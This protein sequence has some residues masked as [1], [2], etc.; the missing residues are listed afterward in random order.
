MRITILAVVTALAMT[1]S[2]SAETH[3][4]LVNESSF[5]PETLVVAPGDTIVFALT[6]GSSYTVVR[7]GSD[8]IPDNAFFAGGL[9]NGGMEGP[10]N[11]SFAWEVPAYASLEIPYFSENSC[12]QGMTGLII[13][14]AGGN[15][16]QV[17]DDYPVL[18]D[19]IEAAQDGDTIELAAGTYYEHDLQLAGKQLTL[20]GETTAGGDPAVTIDAAQQGRVV[21]VYTRL[22][23]PPAV[24]GQA[25]LE[26][27][28][29][30]GGI[31]AGGL[32]VEHASPVVRNCRFIGN[33]RGIHVVSGAPGTP[34]LAANPQLIDCIFEGNGDGAV[35]CGLGFQNGQCQPTLSGCLVTGNMGSFG[36][37]RA[38]E[39]TSVMVYNSIICGNDGVQLLGD[40]QL[41]GDSCSAPI[42]ID[43]DGDGVPEGCLGD[44][45]GILNVP[46]EYP[47]I[48]GAIE[49][50]NDGQTVMIA[51]GTYAF[52]GDGGGPGADPVFFVADKSITIAGE[53]NADGSPAVTIEGNEGDP[54]AGIYVFG[55][56]EAVTL[57]HLKIRGCYIGIT[58]VGGSHALTNCIL[59]NNYFSGLAVQSAQVVASDSVIRDGS[60][61]LLVTGSSEQTDVSLV[62]C[63]IENNTGGIYS[64]GIEVADGHL[65][66][67][68][69]IVRGNAVP[70]WAATG[71]MSI[72]SSAS[73]TLSDTIV[74]ANFV[75]DMPGVQ[76]EGDWTDAGGSTVSEECGST[77]HVPADY[78]TIQ[79]AIDA[80][81]TFDTIELAAGTYAL[82]GD[83]SVLEITNK[84][85]TLIG[86]T[87]PDGTI[88][89]TIQGDPSNSTTSV[90]V[91]GDS[92]HAVTLSHLR[93]SGLNLG[94]QGPATTVTDCIIEGGTSGV[95][96]FEADVT[97]VRC[98][99]R[100]H[101]AIGFCGV[102]VWSVN[103]V[104]TL[105]LV[106]CI[107]ED[108]SANYET[109]G[110]WPP[111]CG[112]IVYG[113]QL[114]VRGCTIRNNLAWGTGGA[115]P[116]AGIGR[117]I[118]KGTGAQDGPFSLQDTSLCG[119]LE[120]GEP[121]DQIFGEVIDGGGNTIEDECTGDCPGDFD[122]SGTVDVSDLLAVIGSWGDP[123]DV[124]DLLLVISEWGESC[125]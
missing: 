27:I 16:L 40:I 55:S 93:M 102:Y 49:F 47:D 9:P 69:C 103:D 73:A 61:G 107:V 58:L 32:L 3:E 116:F 30:T 39:G 120:D 11:F 122:G 82:D 44:Q 52:S 124:G 91:L 41:D 85:L 86:E 111:H 121:Q 70:A 118:F 17:P 59:E 20:R 29:I 117:R 54:P 63:R 78:A 125:P 50:A 76:I 25:V 2:V 71:G 123:Y 24:T 51:A 13:I 65:S 57:E 88:A 98:T 67:E 119:N 56:E 53:R 87:N 12:E 46:D 105:E 99:I 42:C 35:E 28:V 8:C 5:S 84:T 34:T 110:W 95:G 90:M 14:D 6:A 19:A 101:H 48:Q 38:D 68:Q 43:D 31:D 89:A 60:T 81:D 96:I 7:S 33:S 26:N 80:A 15:T 115:S 22:V 18:A 109:F 37:V 106:D 94:I 100:D 97:M 75:G 74:C 108:N 64:G 23:P 104:T 10:P 21:D 36:G 72:D 112:V 77:I 83:E 45:D 113:S 1:T 4:V 62:N 92:S 79:I 66:L 114:S